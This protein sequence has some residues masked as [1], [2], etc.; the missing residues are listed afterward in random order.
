MSTGPHDDNNH[1]RNH[2]DEERAG[3]KEAAARLRVPVATLRYWRTH[4]TWSRAER[5][6]RP[7]S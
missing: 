4:R 7:G 6:R 2:G 1:G 5:G 3:M